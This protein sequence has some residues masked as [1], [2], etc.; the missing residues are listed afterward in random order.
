MSF[1]IQIS[2]DVINRFRLKYGISIS[3]RRVVSPKVS[4]NNL[5]KIATMLD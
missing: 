2:L 1:I 4:I 3:T 5:G